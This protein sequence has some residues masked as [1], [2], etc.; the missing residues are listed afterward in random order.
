[1]ILDKSL[2]EYLFQF[3]WVDKE[4][5]MPKEIHDKWLDLIEKNFY[6]ANKNNHFDNTVS[7]IP[8]PPDLINPE[9]SR[10]DWKQTDLLRELH[11]QLFLKK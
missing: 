3:A 11:N 7:F 1:M 6:E 4:Q 5:N 8:L 2:Y 9:D 10:A